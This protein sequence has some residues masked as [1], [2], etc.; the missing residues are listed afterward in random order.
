MAVG[1]PS[2]VDREWASGGDVTLGAIV[3]AR[4]DWSIARGAGATSPLAKTGALMLLA[5]ACV[6]WFVYSNKKPTITTTNFVLYRKIQLRKSVTKHTRV[7]KPKLRQ[8]K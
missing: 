7:C 8:H 2:S 1:S 3:R 5:V 6:E 4:G